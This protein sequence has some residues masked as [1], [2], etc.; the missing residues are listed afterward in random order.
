VVSDQLQVA[1]VGGGIG[2]LTAAH[3]L[4]MRGLN[5]TVFEQANELREVG[6]GISI[7]ANAAL[8]LERIGLTDRIKAIG[9][10]I[11]GVLLRTSVGEPIDISARPAS[12]V[13]SY[14]LI[15]PAVAD[16][17]K[18]CIALQSFGVRRIRGFEQPLLIFVLAAQRAIAE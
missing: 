4:R 18:G 12:S 5:V 13:Q 7:F 1:I 2:G 17:V 8:L 10:P 6:A 3:A 14:I 9:T 16:G 11:T 15:D